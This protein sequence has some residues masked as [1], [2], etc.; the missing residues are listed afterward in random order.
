MF[1]V[2]NVE[3]WHAIDGC[4][5]GCIRRR[6]D[7]VVGADNNGHVGIFKCGIDVLHF[8]KF[9]VGHVNLS[10]KHIHMSRHT[11]GDRVDRKLDFFSGCLKFYHQR[12]HD[13]LCL[14]KRHTVAGDDNYA[15]GI[16]QPLAAC[17]HRS[18]VISLNLPRDITDAERTHN[19]VQCFFGVTQHQSDV[20]RISLI[21][22]WIVDAGVSG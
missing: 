21:V 16:A 11:T 4:A 5:L 8:M 22:E 18:D 7:D 13:R 14:G 6:V 20:V 10:E 12:F 2:F 19:S 15:L 3:D 1:S 17:L 9:V